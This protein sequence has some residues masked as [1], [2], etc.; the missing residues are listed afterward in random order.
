MQALRGNILLLLACS[1]TVGACGEGV[2]FVV[3]EPDAST[4]ADTDTDVDTD[5]DGDADADTDS[6]ADTDTDADS[7]ADTDTG[8]D[9][10]TG[11]DVACTGTEKIELSWEGAEITAPMKSAVAA[12]QGNMTYI[13]TPKPNQGEARQAFDAPCTGHWYVWAMGIVPRQLT[14]LEQAPH[15]F[16]VGLDDM[17]PVEWALEQ[18]GM[19]GTSAWKWN[20]FDI[21]APTSVAIPTGSHKLAIYGGQS[22]GEGD[23]PSLGRVILST[24]PSFQPQ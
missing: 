15:T 18:P 17:P 13:Y 20:V 11:M 21:D 16:K 2:E 23:H 10:G 12:A 14:P 19:W 7:D 6:D 9:T 5:A 3:G 1:W 22:N 8:S 24:D 4:D